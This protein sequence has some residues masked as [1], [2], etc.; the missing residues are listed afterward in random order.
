MIGRAAAGSALLRT[1]AR[2]VEPCFVRENGILQLQNRF[3]INTRNRRRRCISHVAR[4][5]NHCSGSSVHDGNGALGLASKYL[6]EELESQA[7]VDGDEDVSR[8]HHHSEDSHGDG[9]EHGALPGLQH[10]AA[11]DQQVLVVQ[12]VDIVL[13]TLHIHLQLSGI[14]RRRP[15]AVERSGLQL[16]WRDRP[17]TTKRCD[18]VT[19]I[20]NLIPHITVTRNNAQTGIT[21]RCHQPLLPW[22]RG[23]Q[24]F[25]PETA[26]C[27]RW[28]CIGR[29]LSTAA[30]QGAACSA[31][32]SA[33]GITA[34]PGDKGTGF[35]WSQG[36]RHL[37]G[38]LWASFH[39]RGWQTRVRGSKGGRAAL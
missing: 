5:A 12:P 20:S 16:Q 18:V 22:S 36:D 1:P 24:P 28:G 39:E 4:A 29:A 26:A 27:R 19:I 23:K 13:H 31:V 3:R 17:G 32:R 6:R 34:V 11:G 2:G 38:R 14:P 21:H 35:T 10:V 37:Q 25:A 7:D 9:V 33:A 30:F 15:V 8:V